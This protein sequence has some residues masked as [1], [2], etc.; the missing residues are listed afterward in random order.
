LVTLDATS[1]AL[2]LD[3][4][5][6]DRRDKINHRKELADQHGIA[7]QTLRMRVHRIRSI[8]QHCVF[9]CLKQAVRL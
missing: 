5:Q 9:E 3:Y 8:L 2:V 7:L 1:R 6:D 4:Y